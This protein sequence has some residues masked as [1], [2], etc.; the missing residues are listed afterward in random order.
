MSNPFISFVIPVYNREKILEQ[1]VAS[2]LDTAYDDYEIVLVDN[3][4]KDGSGVICDRL[5]AEHPQ[6]RVLHLP[7]N[8]GAGGARNTGLDHARGA[9]LHFCDSDDA[10][11][12]AILPKIALRLQENPDV[13]IL[14]TNHREQTK[15]GSHT[16]RILENE[17]KCTVD[18]LLDEKPS[19]LHL[20]FWRNFYRRS[21][22]MEHQLRFP[23]IREHEDLY[24]NGLALLHAEK[25]YAMPDVFYQY[26][27]F[28]AANSIVAQSSADHSADGFDVC[29]AA[30]RAYFEEH[31]IQGPKARAAD[32]F[33]YASAMLILGDIAPDTLSAWDHSLENLP[34]KVQP[35]DL[36]FSGR[37][38]IR[39]CVVALWRQIAE[40]AQ[41][42]ITNQRS[43]YLAPAGNFS[44][45]IARMLLERGVGVCGLLDNSVKKDNF[46]IKTTVEGNHFSVERFE[47]FFRENARE[48]GF[49]LITGSINTTLSI[50]R[51]LER[52]GWAFGDDYMAFIR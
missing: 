27:R 23:S 49:V 12:G 48:K 32:C 15:D 4:S 44:I 41:R 26:N 33:V 24:F 14:T 7:I 17:G 19:L 43:I 1:T 6:I 20:S 39:G 18:H 34:D 31:G 3:A 13:D 40:C 42:A 16:V 38:G 47:D 45:S 51:Q 2:I 46:H 11:D 25:A 30:F 5:M 21:F 28:V 37:V 9:F 50:S 29:T 36:T 35:I 10:V 52:Y 8:V 22:V